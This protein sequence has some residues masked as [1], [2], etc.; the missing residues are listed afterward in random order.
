[1]DF[2]ASSGARRRLVKPLSATACTPPTKS[3]NVG[4]LIKFSNNCP[5]AVPM[6]CTPRSAIVLH[7]NA[8]ASVPISST[9]ITSGMWFS[10]ASIMT[11]MLHGRIGHLHATRPSDGGMRHVA[12]TADLIARI[13]DDDA[14]LELIAQHA[15]HLANHGRLPDAG[16][17][18][19]KTLSRR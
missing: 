10:T 18:R 8:S 17:P 2:L 19:N 14:L 1:M 9:M 6:S 3:A 16:R 15:R 5:C 7:A 4:F 11:P 13:D 12:V